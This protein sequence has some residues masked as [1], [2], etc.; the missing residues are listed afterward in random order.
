MNHGSVPA[1][2]RPIRTPRW[3]GALLRSACVSAAVAAVAA[4]H[5]L[6][7]GRIDATFLALLAL[8]LVPWLAPL[9]KSLKFADFEIVF[10]ELERQIAEARGD[11]RSARRMTDTL[12]DGLLAGGEGVNTA[13]DV[14]PDEEFDGLIAVYKRVQKSM[15]RGPA[16][17]GRLTRVM[18]RMIVLGPRLRSLDVAGALRGKDGGKR[19]AAYAALYARPDGR[20]LP[21][22]LDAVTGSKQ[23]PFSTFWG[24]KAAGKVL[25][26]A[27]PADVRAAVFRLEQFLQRELRP[28]T[29]R[30]RELSIILRGFTGGEPSPDAGE[31]RVP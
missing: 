5:L 21:D 1:R 20:L 2:R 16:K 13:A 4:A 25:A 15:K 28:G 31:R 29:D 12:A 30:H 6:F 26:A 3:K 14:P 8:A 23:R 7:P 10:R 11:A 27:D 9:V 24:I 22:L 19:V 18:S 17:T